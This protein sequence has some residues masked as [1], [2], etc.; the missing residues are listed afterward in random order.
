MKEGVL[1]E[2]TLIHFE[3]CNRE[4]VIEM[5][6]G[7][8]VSVVGGVLEFEDNDLLGFRH[9]G[10][11]YVTYDY[12]ERNNLIE[13]LMQRDYQNREINPI[14]DEDL[15]AYKVKFPNGGD[16]PYPWMML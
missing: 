14:K 11:Y 1:K 15:M 10:E 6:P 8:P 13:D 9:D 4:G 5:S 7:T 16:T 3:G 2:K 12:D